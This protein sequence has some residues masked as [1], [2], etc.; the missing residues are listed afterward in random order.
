[1]KKNNLA[2]PWE[3]YL[4][5]APWIIGL[6]AFTIIPMIAS[7]YFSFTRYDMANPPKFIGLTNYIAM[8]SD[9]RL[10][11]SLLVTIRFVVISVPLQLAFALLIATVLRKN[12]RGVPVYRAIYYLPS[13]LGGSVAIALLWRQVFNKDGLF[14]QVLALFGVTGR[15][16]IASPGTVLYTLMALAA[17]QFGGSMVIFLGGLRNISME[18]YEAAEIDG[19]GRFQVFVSITLPLLT[20]MIFFNL[21]MS[22]IGSF[23]SFTSSFIV[24]GGTGGPID[25]TLFYSL[26][27][28]LKAFKSFDMGYAS[29]MAWVLLVIIGVITALMFALSKIWVYYDE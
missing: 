20:P 10:H 12:R 14:N 16:W 18:Y 25:A 6:L 17:W 27:L 21:V 23:Q 1:M 7:F 24:S 29:A 11:T 26:Y 5:L 4:F 22:I 19:A 9:K 2:K 8:L 3:A 15:N 28:Y 13:L